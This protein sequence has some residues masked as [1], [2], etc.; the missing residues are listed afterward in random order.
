M[1]MTAPLDDVNAVANEILDR[2]T[3]EGGELDP[4]KLQKLLYYVQVVSIVDYGARA[5]GA[6]IEAW[7][8]GPVVREIWDRFKKFK[9]TPIAYQPTR[10]P[11]LEP[12][13]LSAISTA[14]LLYGGMTG[15]ALSK[16]THVEKPWIAA[17]GV[18]QNTVIS[19]EHIIN[20]YVRV[21]TRVYPLPLNQETSEQKALLEKVRALR[22][23]RDNEEV[24]GDIAEQDY[25]LL[26]DMVLTQT[27]LDYRLMSDIVAGIAEDWTQHPEAA[28]KA[29]L[30]ALNR[31]EPLIQEAALR[32]LERMW[33]AKSA[34]E[35]LAAL[36]AVQDLAIAKPKWAVAV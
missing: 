25:G 26:T 22:I 3:R 9:R 12:Y 18:C 6:D 8:E 14:L 35:D 24:I 27:T 5:F 31:P 4:L 15:E 19:M 28:Q 23:D 7:D 16:Q 20:G 13:V 21:G 32:G 33:R 10:L 2:V 34:S 17:Y 29:L 36:V 30:I 11:P 1:P